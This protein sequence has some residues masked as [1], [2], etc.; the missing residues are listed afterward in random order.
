MRFRSGLE[1]RTG[2]GRESTG[3]SWLSQQLLLAKR[4]LVVFGVVS[5]CMHVCVCVCPSLPPCPPSLLGLLI[6]SLSVS[7][8][9]LPPS[10]SCVSVCVWGGGGA[11]GLSIIAA[12][13]NKVPDVGHVLD[14]VPSFCYRHANTCYYSPQNLNPR[15]RYLSCAAHILTPPHQHPHTRC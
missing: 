3:V 2:A 10:L 12:S 15:V 8:G 14:L 11:P 9:C 13:S 7:S 5:V 4:K 1:V 6:S